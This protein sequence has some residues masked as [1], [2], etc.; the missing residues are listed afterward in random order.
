LRPVFRAIGAV[1]PRRPP[2]QKA[3]APKKAP[4]PKKAAATK[5]AAAPPKK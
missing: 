3:A 5:M 2:R 1:R 4:A